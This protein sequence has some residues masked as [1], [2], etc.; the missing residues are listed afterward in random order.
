[1]STLLKDRFYTV[2]FFDKL[3][4]LLEKS[5]PGF[6]KNSFYSHLFCPDWKEMALKEKMRHTAQSLRPFMPDDFPEAAALLE[7]IVRLV[8]NEPIGEG[9][10]EFMSLPDYVELYGQEHYDASVHCMETVTQIASC[11]FAVRPFLLKYEEKMIAQ[12]LRWSLHDNEHVRRLASEGIRPRLP[13]AMGL[14]FLKKDPAPILPILENLKNDPSETVRR[15]VANNLNDISKD[16]PNIVLNIAGQWKGHSP[17]TDALIKH[18]CRT[19]LKQGHPDIMD[20]YD[21]C[22][23]SAEITNFRLHAPA[24]AIGDK[25]RFSFT[26]KN[27]SSEEQTLR[28]EY[29][30]YYLRKNGSYSKKVFKISEKNFAPGECTEIT[31]HQSFAL[32][33]TRVFYHGTQRISLIANGKEVQQEDFLLTEASQS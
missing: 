23:K 10:F 2:D 29:G 30:L 4:P 18:A 1:M 19:L 32:I 24:V 20:H 7:K 17:K 9:C 26:V 21:L 13:W 28:L 12:M 6:D 27:T 5:I 25:L 16:H 11:E 15:S 8:Q 31:R 14:P 3:S 33:T 22:D